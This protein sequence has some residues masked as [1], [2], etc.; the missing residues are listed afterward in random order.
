M[1]LW[2]CTGCQARVSLRNCRC[3]VEAMRL[4]YTFNFTSTQVIFSRYRCHS[5]L[6]LLAHEKDLCHN[7]TPH[8]RS[9]LLTEIDLSIDQSSI[10]TFRTRTFIVGQRRTPAS[11]TTNHKNGS[12]PNSAQRR[13]TR[14]TQRVL[15]ARRPERPTPTKLPWSFPHGPRR[16]MA[17]RQRSK[18]VRQR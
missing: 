5:N 1:C 2:W 9:R 10:L 4:S 8:T 7:L 14:R 16:Q 6:H 15:L 3:F 11:L 13:L 12:S 18:L 17:K